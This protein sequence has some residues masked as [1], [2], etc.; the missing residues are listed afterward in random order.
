MITR[1]L[2]A[3]LAAGCTAVIKVRIPIFQFK[4]AELILIYYSLLQTRH[5]QHLRLQN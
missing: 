4:L 3:V 2:G 5:S 1:K